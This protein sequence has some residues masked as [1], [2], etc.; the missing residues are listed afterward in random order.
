M[1][2]MDP[3]G[4]LQFPPSGE[5]DNNLECIWKI[6]APFGTVSALSLYIH[7]ILLHALFFSH[8][9]VYLFI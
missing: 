8:S 5:Y 4:Q 9:F 7:G 2:L 1:L 3:A 6:S